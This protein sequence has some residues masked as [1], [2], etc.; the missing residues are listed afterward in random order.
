MQS[1][2]SRFLGQIALGIS[3]LLLLVTVFAF[4]RQPD[5]LAA[6]TVL[7][8]W[9]WGSM[10]LMLSLG[11]LYFV[12]ARFSLILSSVW[13]ITIL[14]GADEARVLL[15]Y[16]QSPPLP[17]RAEPFEGKPVI[18]VITQNCAI[19]LFGSPA[20]DIAAWHPDIVLLQDVYPYQAKQIADTLYGGHGDFRYHETNAIVTRYKIEREITT[21]NRRVQ[22]VTLRL[23]NGKSIEVVNVHL[24]TATTDL[25]FWQKSAWLNHRINRSIRDT[26]LTQTRQILEHSTDLPHTPTLFGG[27]F[28]SP[29]TDVVHRQLT[30][31]F[32]DA[33]AAV[34]TGWGDTFQH[35]LPILRI[36]HLY[37]NRLFTPVRC[38]AVT[39]RHSDH[40]MVVADFLMN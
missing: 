15:H 28:N 33:F 11:A 2:L 4:A 6:F 40:R 9:L 5:R 37:A 27:D 23:P 1:T 32:V 24:A 21:P 8:I 36:D 7:P 13:A 30:R 17:G 34:G 22:E 38:R 18:R 26:E 16:N 19:F 12:R 31:D 29:A 14:V 20:Q 25:R 39:T 10:G 35:R 3:L